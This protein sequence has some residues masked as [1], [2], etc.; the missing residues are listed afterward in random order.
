MSSIKTIIN[1]EVKN[2]AEV[3]EAI[4]R[5]KSK[6]VV[7]MELQE[8]TFS[9]SQCIFFKEGYC[10]NKKILAIVSPRGCCNLYFPAKKDEK[11]SEN[12][13]INKK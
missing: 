1:E 13:Q 5:L 2:V 10:K 4:E 7:Y 6:D 8:S 9:C 11:P 3:K 12:W